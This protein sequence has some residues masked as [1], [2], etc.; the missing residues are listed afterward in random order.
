MSAA[1]AVVGMDVS[2]VERF[3]RV[4][5]RSESLC[6]S[7]QI[8]DYVLQAA[9]QASPTKWHLAHV[10]WFFETFLLEPFLPGYQPFRPGYR[11]L[12]NSYYDQVSGGYFPRHQRGL[13]SRPT[14]AEVYEYRAHIDQQMAR[15]LAEPDEH[16]AAVALRLN[17][18]LNHEQQHQELLLTDIKY[19]LSVNPLDPAYRDDLSAS[20]STSRSSPRSSP[21][22]T[23]RSTL[24]P[25]AGAVGEAGW[26]RCEGGL[27]DIGHQGEGFGFDN[28]WP[29][30]RQFLP[31]YQL[32][33]RLVSNADYLQFIEAGG[34]QDSAHWLSDGWAAVQQHGWQA[35]LYWRQQDGEWWTLTLGGLRPIEPAEPV[36]HISYYE[37]EAYAAWAGH[38][39]PTEVEWE[40]A[41]QGLPISGNF[42]D[43]GSLHPQPDS[44]GEG[45]R[46][47]FG[48][49][50]EWTGSAYRPYPGY[51]PP[52]GAIGEYNGKF[53][54]NQMVL[55][56]GS[57]VTSVDHIR[58]SYRNFFYPHERWQFMG[59][60]LAEDG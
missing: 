39:L 60:R 38:R 17:I 22:S 16:A 45:L 29:R 49:V 28:E 5:R 46:Q 13:L 25:A 53:M 30:H 37:A 47:M 59:L 10:S 52:K 58:R 36:V 43:Q 12:F 19:N 8:E 34:Y 3:Q 24:G 57:C 14:V 1:G 48:D 51:R 11:Y 55:R 26:S 7:L 35:P 42:L 20:R 56:G 54:S 15:L 23:P 44:G 21:R 6:E 2:A 40:H 32:A 41:A 50:W 4:R 31:P 33:N 27:V 18:G 9:P